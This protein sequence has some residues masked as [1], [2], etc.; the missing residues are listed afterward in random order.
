MNREGIL[1]LSLLGVLLATPL[2]ARAQENAPS[3][4]DLKA[5]NELLRRERE[6][7]EVRVR[8]LTDQVEQLRTALA[9]SQ[10][11]A[12]SIEEQHRKVLGELPRLRPIQQVD[13]KLNEIAS[14]TE[15]ERK[16]PERL[17][18]TVTAVGNEG[19][20]LQ[21]SLG[22]DAGLKVGQVLE[23]FRTGSGNQKPLY[24]GTLTLVRV[25]AQASLGQFKSVVGQNERARVGDEVAKDLTGK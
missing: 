10:N 19:R 13:G 7:L 22:T 2:P 14:R 9:N 25:D 23:V 18:G 1:K 11:Q 4:A 8:I 24:L 21:T 16:T 3:A 15:S 20:L 6:L 12:R 17:P 5:Q